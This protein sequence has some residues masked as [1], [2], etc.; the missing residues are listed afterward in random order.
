[1]AAKRQARS[2]QA[3]IEVW[4]EGDRVLIGV[5][6]LDNSE[7]RSDSI[8]TEPRQPEN[9]KERRAREI[10]Q[11]LQKLAT[12]DLLTHS[13]SS[14]ERAE[15]SRRPRR[16]ADAGRVEA[17]MFVMTEDEWLTADLL[18]LQR[19]AVDLCRSADETLAYVAEKCAA[20]HRR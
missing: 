2:A 12:V 9:E 3:M 20:V 5:P 11:I 10:A 13:R 4:R 14:E 16:Q 7:D 6:S 17:E 1:M 19:Q 15:P 8:A 18:A